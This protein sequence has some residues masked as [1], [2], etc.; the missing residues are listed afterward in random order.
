[1]E[2]TGYKGILG[3]SAVTVAAWIKTVSTDNGAIVGWGPNVAAE[4]WNSH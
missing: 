3:S 2:I 4:N 1:M